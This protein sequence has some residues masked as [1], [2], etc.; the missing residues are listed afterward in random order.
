MS[1]DNVVVPERVLSLKGLVRRSR[2]C[3]A[4]IDHAFPFD[5]QPF[6]RCEVLKCTKCGSELDEETGFGVYNDENVQ[7]WPV[8]ADFDGFF[9]P[10]HRSLCDGDDFT[11]TLHL[12]KRLRRKFSR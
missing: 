7:I 8:P 9:V 3:Q 2:C 6:W 4:E 10:S 12:P 5:S 1:C 11:H